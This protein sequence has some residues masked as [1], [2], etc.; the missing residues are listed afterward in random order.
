[1]YIFAKSLSV[2][3]T[4]GLIGVSLF[5]TSSAAQAQ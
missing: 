5:T 1:M 2:T 4:V 3:A